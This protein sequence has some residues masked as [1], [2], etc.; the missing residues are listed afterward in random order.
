LNGITAEKSF[1]EERDS[2]NYSLSLSLS[3]SAGMRELKC[4]FIEIKFGLVNWKN[5]MENT[6]VQ[7][8]KRESK[9]SR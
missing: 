5:E 4:H 3:L 6:K 9:G 7:N 8:P 1:P 2:D